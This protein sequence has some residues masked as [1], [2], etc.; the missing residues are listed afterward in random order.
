M[1]VIAAKPKGTPMPSDETLW[2]L[3][4][5]NPGGAGIMYNLLHTK[6]LVRIRKGFMTFTE[7][8]DA[9]DLLVMDELQEQEQTI[10]FHFRRMKNHNPAYTHPYPIDRPDHI[11]DL[12]CNCHLG[13][14]QNGII[15][16]EKADF[17]ESR[18]MTFTK[19]ILSPMY[20]DE[21]YFL[22]VASTRNLLYRTTNCRMAFLYGDGS[23]RLVGEFQQHNGIYYSN[24]KFDQ[25][26][27]ELDET[28]ESS[29][30]LC[31]GVKKYAGK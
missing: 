13:V 28:T 17:G 2:N 9:L 29:Y 26:P 18:N 15:R 7:L 6:T 21:P 11:L 5:A 24:F 16:T 4:N 10:V 20:E 12:E 25:C 22:D 8:M 23:L 31:E 14:A 19:R 3:W 27:K 30:N 1:C